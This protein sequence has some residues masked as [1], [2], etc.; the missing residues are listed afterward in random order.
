MYQLG[1]KVLNFRCGGFKLLLQDFIIKNSIDNGNGI[2]CLDFLEQFH[3]YFSKTTITGGGDLSN[4]SLGD[5]EDFE[6]LSTFIEK[7]NN[8]CNCD[9]PDQY[10]YHVLS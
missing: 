5:A 6:S 2:T 3:R 8:T 4:L 10:G 1:T 7:A 9:K